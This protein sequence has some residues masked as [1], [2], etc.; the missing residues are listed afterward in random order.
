M[1]LTLSSQ[2]ES[3][4]KGSPSPRLTVSLSTALVRLTMRDATMPDV[5]ALLLAAA[6]QNVHNM[7]IY[8]Y[9]C[10]SVIH[11]Y[12]YILLVHS[13]IL[14]DTT[15]CVYSLILSGRSAMQRQRVGG[16]VREVQQG[17]EENAQR[18]Q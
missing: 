3:L 1:T 6:R 11:I 4:P 8:I 14:Y 16:V 17:L 10:V 5:C 2:T 13:H 18:V 7:C 9:V 15:S 12:M